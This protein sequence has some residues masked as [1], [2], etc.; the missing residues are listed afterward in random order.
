MLFG[1]INGLAPRTQASYYESYSAFDSKLVDHFPAVIP[2]SVIAVQFGRPDFLDR[3][4]DEINFYLKIGVNKEDFD[5]SLSNLQNNN[6][7]IV[8]SSGNCLF[9]IDSGSKKSDLCENPL[10]ISSDLVEERNTDNTIFFLECKNQKIIDSE[11]LK[12]K[13]NLPPDWNNGYSR[14]VVFNKKEMTITYWLHIW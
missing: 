14:G 3:I 9:F 4:Q 5:Q 13:T 12:P 10:F 1:C 11:Y 8:P 2:N 7:K 6:Y